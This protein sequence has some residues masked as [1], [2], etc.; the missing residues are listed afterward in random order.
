[1]KGPVIIEVMTDPWEILGPKA[2]SK[3]LKD[4]RMVSAPL[5]DMAPFLPREKFKESMI[6]SPDAEFEQLD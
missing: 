4:G 6:I 2:A 5:E 3:R 1:L